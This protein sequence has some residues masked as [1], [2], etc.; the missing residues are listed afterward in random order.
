MFSSLTFLLFSILLIIYF[1]LLKNVNIL[2]GYK[3]TKIWHILLF[4]IITPTSGREKFFLLAYSDISNSYCTIA[5]WDFL[6]CLKQISISMTLKLLWT[7]SKHLSETCVLERYLY[8]VVHI[9][10]QCEDLLFFCHCYLNFVPLK[11]KTSSKEVTQ[12]FTFFEQLNEKTYKCSL[13]RINV[14]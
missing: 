9:E 12:R 10:I 8:T 5:G 2:V 1:L 4:P 7:P 3:N 11:D 13:V 14:F 6:N